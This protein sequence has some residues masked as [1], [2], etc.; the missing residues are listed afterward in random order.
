MKEF[1]VFDW[2]EPSFLLVSKQKA[3]FNYIFR[4]F[5]T[6]MD[7]PKVLDTLRKIDDEEVKWWL[8]LFPNGI[9]PKERAKAKEVLLKQ[10]EDGGRNLYYA[11]LCC[12][13]TEERLLLMNL[14]AEKKFP[15][16]FYALT[17]SFSRDHNDRILREGEQLNDAEA[18]YC[19]YIWSKD[20]KDQHFYLVKSA[21]LGDSYGINE[22]GKTLLIDDCLRW[23]LL[24]NKTLY[25]QWYEEAMDVT[26][27]ETLFHIGEL[28]KYV[29]ARRNIDFLYLVSA[30]AKK[31]I[32][33]VK[34]YHKFVKD[35]VREECVNWCLVARKLGVNKDIRGVI[36][37]MIWL[38]RKEGRH[39]IL[40]M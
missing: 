22:F 34:W 6:E 27:N 1:C 21:R 23:T 3:M 14:S 8:S 2:L 24:C 7:T 11:A 31:G 10:P 19:S 20:S 5:K 33:K 18:C 37:K 25:E 13:D 40:A 28:S 16:S 15:R 36:A 12:V 35:T 9:N 38:T 4:H 32:Q 26:S 30:V 29:D 17:A 39:S